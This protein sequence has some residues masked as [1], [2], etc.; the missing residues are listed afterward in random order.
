MRNLIPSLF[1]S[2]AL[3]ACGSSSPSTP[4]VVDAPVAPPTVDAAIAGTPSCANY[5]SEVM[6][7]CTGANAQY[8]DPAHCMATCATFPVG[9]LA[10]NGGENTLGCRLY[11]GGAPSASSP[12]PHC[13]H[14]GPAGDVIS[15]ATVAEAA[16][17]SV[18]G[19][20]CTS[21]CTLEIAACGVTGANN[22]N[23]QYASQAACITACKAFANS[24]HAYATNAGG[25]SLACRLL[26]ATN[27]IV[28]GNA[29]T[30]CPHTGPS[31]AGAGNPC[32]AGKVAT[33]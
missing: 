4:P 9:T 28:T 10:D 11:H 26:H 3:A 25:D 15:T 24:D 33:P 19:D 1:V 22:A 31:P 5:C 13:F 29:A 12:V 30:H 32:L 18:C 7:N 17:A 23:G 14:A 16:S 21:F 8:A 20:P 2:L 27:A 6:T